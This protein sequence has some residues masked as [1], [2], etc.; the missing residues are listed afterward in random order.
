MQKDK[1][2]DELLKQHALE[3][4]SAD[5]TA[6][7]MNKIAALQTSKYNTTSP[8]QSGLLKILIGVFVFVCIM[9]LVAS[10]VMHPFAP[11]IKINMQPPF[12]TTQLIY[13]FIAFWVVML[14]NL[15]WKQRINF[16]A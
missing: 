4:T 5:F 8:F 12:Y 7:A 1:K 6:G 3:E 15:W 10:I 11:A 9:L 2:L 14:A 13:F 16:A